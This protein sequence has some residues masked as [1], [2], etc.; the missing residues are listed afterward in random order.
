VLVHLGAATQ[1]VF[2][3][4]R[5]KLTDVVAF[6]PGPGNAMLDAMVFHGTRGREANDRGGK[7]AVQGCCLDPLLAR[8]LDHPHLTRRPPKAVHPEAFGRSF[9]LAGFDAARQL[10]AGLPDLLCTA[11]HLI[12]ARR[13]R[14][15]PR[16]AAAAGRAAANRAQR[17]RGAE[18]VPVAA[19]GPRVR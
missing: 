14:G 17:R 12:A 1:L 5:A 2:V 10:G 11:T 9:L 19:A 15:V 3:P 16:L 8:W 6:E 13:R 18:R 4:A 7:K